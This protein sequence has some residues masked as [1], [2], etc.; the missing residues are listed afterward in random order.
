MAERVR[1]WEFWR[2]GFWTRPVLMFLYAVVL[3]LLA[4]ALAGAG[5]GALRAGKALDADRVCGAGE[6]EDCLER[7]AGVLDGP[8]YQRGP[9]D[10]WWIRPHSGGEFLDADVDRTHRDELEPYAGATVTGLVHEGDLVAIDLPAERVVTRSGGVRG[11][12]FFA[13]MSLLCLAGALMVFSSG[14]ATGTKLGWFSTSLADRGDSRLATVAFVT[15][16]VLFAPLLFAG[17]PLFFGAPMWV[18]VGSL[19]LMLACGAL[20][21]VRRT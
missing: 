18:I 5:V 7:A 13:A 15:A 17:L 10:E 20:V 9:G 4:L 12:M 3:V 2:R 19:G 6:T 8:H 14:W 11:A 1:Q 16:C 21:V